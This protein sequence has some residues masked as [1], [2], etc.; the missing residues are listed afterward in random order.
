MHSILGVI[1]LIHIPIFML[2]QEVDFN[3]FTAH[4]ISVVIFLL[5]VRL[6][7]SMG[8]RKSLHDANNRRLTELLSFLREGKQKVQAKTLELV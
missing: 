5:P 2:S 8:P 3:E 4:K 7:C 6:R 1:K